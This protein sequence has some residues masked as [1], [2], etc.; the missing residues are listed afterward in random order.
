LAQNLPFHSLGFIGT[1]VARLDFVP[2][3]VLNSKPVLC[4]R[5]RY[6]QVLRCV[7]QS[8]ES[9]DLKAI[10]V[11]THGED[12][13]VQIWNK[14]TASS[15]DAEKHYT[16]AQISN[17]EIHAR[18]SRD[19]SAGPPNLLSLSQVLRLAGNYVD[20]MRGRLVRVSWQ[21]Q[22]EKI[23]SITV[24]YEPPASDRGEPSESKIATIEELC[25]H[26]YKQRKKISAASDK[27]SRRPFV[28]VG[29][30]D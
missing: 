9:V 8:L 12:F 6:S 13:V 17:L 5:L 21:E 22:S 15:M 19:S 4:G 14:G 20:R 16:P 25:V 23:Q 26:V 30:V 11:K 28:S 1:W 7:G 3:S 24:Q 2:L 29:H 10:E 27:Y 18:T